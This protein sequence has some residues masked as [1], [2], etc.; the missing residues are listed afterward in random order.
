[1]VV[2]VRRPQ[3]ADVATQ[4]DVRRIA[5]ALPGAVEVPGEFR[6]TVDG[7]AFA[8]PWRERVD[9]RRARVPN[10]DVLAVRI[11]HESD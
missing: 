5:L 10:L 7:R 8:W 1:M 9:P 4:D 11:A 3:P 6:F 2:V